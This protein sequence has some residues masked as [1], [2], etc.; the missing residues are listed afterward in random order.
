MFVVSRWTMLYTHPFCHS[1]QIVASVDRCFYSFVLHKSGNELF[2]HNLP[3][4]L[5]F[6]LELQQ[7]FQRP[8][9]YCRH[10]GNLKERMPGWCTSAVRMERGETSAA[11]NMASIFWKATGEITFLRSLVPCVNLVPVRYRVRRKMPTR[12]RINHF[13]QRRTDLIKK[14]VLALVQCERIQTTDRKA[15]QL[16]KYGDLV[17]LNIIN[18]WIIIWW[19]LKSVLLRFFRRGRGRHC[20][21]TPC[22]SFAPH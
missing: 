9:P 1:W 4:F 11:S 22:I 10:L 12:K 3:F 13:V 14:L 19:Y 5:V 18:L 20:R 8:C 17:K 15:Q 6:W 7:M 21:K 2:V 16:K